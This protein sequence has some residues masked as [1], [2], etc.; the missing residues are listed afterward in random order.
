MHFLISIRNFMRLQTLIQL[1]LLFLNKISR[2]P[3]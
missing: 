2:C 3:K 1:L